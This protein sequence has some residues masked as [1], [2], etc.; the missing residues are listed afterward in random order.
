MADGAFHCRDSVLAALPVLLREGTYM[1]SSS[2]SWLQSYGVLTN[3]V[4]VGP[5]TLFSVILC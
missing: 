1:R 5:R 2:L 4:V 3:G